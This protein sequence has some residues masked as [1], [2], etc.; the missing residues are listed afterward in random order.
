MDGRL[1]LVLA[2]LALSGCQ[3]GVDIAIC[4]HGQDCPSGT[5][6]DEELGVCR[7]EDPPPPPTGDDDGDDGDEDDKAPGPP[8][9]TAEGEGEGEVGEG[10]GEP[11]VPLDVPLCGDGTREGAEECDDANRVSGDGC[12][13]TCRVDSSTPEV[14]PN[15]YPGDSGS[16][17]MPASSVFVAGITNMVY[18]EVA[19]QSYPEADTFWLSPSAPAVVR[20]ESYTRS[21]VDDCDGYSGFFVDLYREDVATDMPAAY[22]RGAW[23]NGNG[24]C[25]VLTTTLTARPH[26]IVILEDTGAALVPSYRVQATVLDDRGAEQEPNDSLADAES[27]A[28]DGL[29]ATMNG[30]LADAADVDVYRVDLPPGRGVR[31]EIIPDAETTPCDAFNTRVSLLDQGGVER[32]SRASMIDACPY[33]DGTGN[34]PKNPEAL[35][36]TFQARTVYVAVSKGSSGLVGAL[37]Y[38]L[39]LT[40]R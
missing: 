9:A 12:S 2:A 26:M 33:I 19:Q 16:V 27:A 6:C 7:A 24:R 37:P 23:G 40:V 30:T 28:R 29:D 34:A 1:P 35:N 20:I 22:L 10:E 25:G 8:P 4:R 39:A 17:V 13:S 32:A 38:R 21:D 14:E 3:L 11:T 31:A 18:D 5:A 15:D 36:L